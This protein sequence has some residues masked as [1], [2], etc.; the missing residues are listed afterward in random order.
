M[1]KC[2]ILTLFLLQIHSNINLQTEENTAIS[3]FSVTFMISDGPTTG[4]KWNKGGGA[5]DTA[6]FDTLTCSRLVRE[7]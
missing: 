2:K 1:C 4:R 5:T 3:K 7:S 6:A